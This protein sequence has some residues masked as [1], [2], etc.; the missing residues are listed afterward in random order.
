LNSLQNIEQQG[1]ARKILNDWDLTLKN[2]VFEAYL[3]GFFCKISLKTGFI[4]KIFRIKEL[5]TFTPSWA[6]SISI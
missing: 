3:L 4:C 1:V 2:E 6:R 5:R